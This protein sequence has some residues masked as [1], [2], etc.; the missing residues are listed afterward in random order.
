MIAAVS[1]IDRDMLEQV[2]AE[3][4]YWL[5]VYHVTKGG[6]REPL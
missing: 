5:N 4:D 2:W 6:Y 3:I 1:E